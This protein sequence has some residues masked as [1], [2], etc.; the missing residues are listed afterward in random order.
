M[1]SK[2]DDTQPTMEDI[3]N[4]KDRYFDGLTDEEFDQLFGKLIGQFPDL[5]FP[6]W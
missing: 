6:T 1:N 5:F 4:L 2:A 3:A